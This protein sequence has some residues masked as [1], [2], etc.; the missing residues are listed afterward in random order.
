MNTL[1]RIK[2]LDDKE[3]RGDTT[4]GLRRWR[5]LRNVVKG[6]GLFKRHEAKSIRV[7][8]IDHEV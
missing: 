3:R 7:D 2:T 5:R 4:A 8:D 6:V 1:S